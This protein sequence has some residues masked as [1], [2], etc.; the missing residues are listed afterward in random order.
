M[1]RSQHIMSRYFVYLLNLFFV[2]SMWVALASVY[3]VSYRLAS[4]PVRSSLVYISVCVCVTRCACAMVQVPACVSLVRACLASCLVR[5]TGGTLISIS[6][7]P[8]TRLRLTPYTQVEATTCLIRTVLRATS[9]RLNLRH[10]LKRFE[11][12]LI[13]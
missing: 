2:I 3:Y 5:A 8:A 11:G 1:Y 6:P 9:F 4:L 7:F 13:L 12:F 10:D